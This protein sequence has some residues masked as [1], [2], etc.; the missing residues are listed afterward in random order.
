MAPWTP[1][2]QRTA[3]AL[4]LV[5]FGA[6]AMPSRANAQASRE[7]PTFA[8]TPGVGVTVRRPD[9]AYDP[10]NNVYLVVSGRAD[11]RTLRQRR[12]RA[13]RR[14]FY[15]PQSP[16]TTRRPR[17]AYG[18]ALGGFLVTWLDVRADPRG[19]AGGGDAWSAS[20]PGGAPAFVEQRLPHRRRRTRASTPSAAPRSRISTVSKRFLVRLPSAR[21]RRPCAVPTTSAASSC[22]GQRRAGR[23]RHQRLLR[24]SLPGRG[25]RRLQPD[26]ATVPGRCTAIT[27]SPRARRRCRPGR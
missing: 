16:P 21:R 18:A 24:Q 27:T 15:I 13:A 10:G 23:R 4:A 9:V 2:F 5:T 22:R 12:W 6:L 11:A 7:G 3:A 25:R 8:A 17:V 14:E 19:G 26:D 1:T 20:A